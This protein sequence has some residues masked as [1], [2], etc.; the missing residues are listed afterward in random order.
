MEDEIAASRN[1]QVAAKTQ[2]QAT[3]DA[4]CAADKQDHEDTEKTLAVDQE[5]LAILK[6]TCGSS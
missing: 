1:D 2:V 4:K 3:A 6:E 5:Y